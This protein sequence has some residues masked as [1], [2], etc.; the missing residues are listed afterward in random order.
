MV[1]KETLETS[2]RDAIRSGDVVRKRTLRMILAAIKLAEVERRGPLD[3][4]G[5]L[6]V[7]QR[8]AKTRHETIADAERAGRGDLVAA[9][10]AE[11]ALVESYLP[12]PLTAE[13]L[14][15]LARQAITE[16]GA[17]APG[18]MGK[19]M[20]VLVPQVQGR[21]DGKAV[22]DLVR[23]LLTPSSPSDG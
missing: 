22:S 4:A 12:R 15:A 16:V 5:M 2:L 7:F 10:K 19:V 1:A 21:A 9:A 18:E 20:R 14:E 8:E 11:L 13:E 17:S 6:G 3:D 23:R